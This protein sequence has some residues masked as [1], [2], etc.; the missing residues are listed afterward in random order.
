VE[1]LT[2]DAVYK[3]HPKGFIGL[4]V[5]GINERDLALP[6]NAGSGVTVS[7]PLIS[8]WRNIRI[9]TL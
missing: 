8:R 1:D 4:Q 5:H 3:T 9:R 6:V 7:Q 2:L